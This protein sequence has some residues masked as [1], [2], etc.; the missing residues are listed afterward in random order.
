MPGIIRMNSA[1]APLITLHDAGK[2]SSDVVFM[3][4]TLEQIETFVAVNL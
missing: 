2:A 1:G 3:S 4:I